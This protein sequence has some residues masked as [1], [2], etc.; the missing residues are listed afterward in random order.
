LLTGEFVPV[1]KI[2][3]DEIVADVR[4]RGD[5]LPNIFS[6]TLVVKEQGIA[7]VTR[8]VI[9][10][11]IGKIGKALYDT[12][13]KEYGLQREVNKL[14]RIVAVVPTVL[15]IGVTVLF[16]LTRGGWLPGVLVGLSLAIALLPS[17]F[18]VIFAVFMA[19]GAWR[20]SKKNVLTRRTSAAESTA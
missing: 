12:E 17:E 10:T 9:K 16:A 1:R 7:Q 14:L 8:T 2:A 19:L 18:P 11:E 20:M 4:P 3:D 15:S 13:P 5:D 6:G